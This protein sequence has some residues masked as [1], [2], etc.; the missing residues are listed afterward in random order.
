MEISK[1]EAKHILVSKDDFRIIGKLVPTDIK[2]CRRIFRA[3]PSFK[4]NYPLLKKAC[5]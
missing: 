5:K 3:W 4:K 1:K 2:L